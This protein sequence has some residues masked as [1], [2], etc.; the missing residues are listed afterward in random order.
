MTLIAHTWPKGFPMQKNVSS[1]FSAFSHLVSTNHVS[2][3][4]VSKAQILGKVGS[5]VLGLP[6]FWTVCLTLWVQNVC[7][8]R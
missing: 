8:M 4:E 3:Q 5:W 6:A 2:C 7:K 1:S